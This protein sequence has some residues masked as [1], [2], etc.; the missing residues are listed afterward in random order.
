M[1]DPLTNLPFKFISEVKDFR[2]T[3]LNDDSFMYREIAKKDG[4]KLKNFRITRLDV[5]YHSYFTTIILDKYQNK[6]FD[7]INSFSYDYQANILILLNV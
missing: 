3:K 2:L 5:L 7:Y 4:H 6:P 1:K